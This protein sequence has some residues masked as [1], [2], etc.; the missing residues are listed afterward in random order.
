MPFRVSFFFVQQTEKSGGW[1]ENYWSNLSDLT[2]AVAKAND[3]I[4][5]LLAVHGHT[6]YVTNVRFSE[7]GGFRRTFVPG[8]GYTF[9]PEVGNNV[10]SDYPTTALLLRLSQAPNYVVNQWVRGIPDSQVAGGGFYQP[11]KSV[12]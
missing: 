1:S 10:V 7:V 6:T 12:V 2:T 3:L 11:R 4:P 8:T 5:K 9:N